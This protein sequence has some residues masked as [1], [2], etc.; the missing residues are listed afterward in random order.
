MALGT[1]GAPTNYSILKV[2]RRSQEGTM[3]TEPKHIL[4]AF[5]LA[6]ACCV[7]GAVTARAENYPADNSGT[8]VRD[9]HGTT[10]TAGDQS[11]SASDVAITKKVR[12]ALVADKSLSTNAHNVKV[13]TRDG[14]VTLRGPVKTPQEKAKIAATAQQVAGV[15]H[16]DDQ[17]EVAS[18]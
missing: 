3:R 15:A 6:V 18:H 14:V 11:A 1:G 16:V 12:Q 7:G 17:L 4:I 10:L 9:R 13:I 2:S 8:N 5:A